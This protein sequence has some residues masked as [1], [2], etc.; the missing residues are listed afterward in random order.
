MEDANLYLIRRL[1]ESSGYFGKS[2]SSRYTNW[3]RNYSIR[4]AFYRELKRIRFKEEP[5]KILEIGCSDGWLIYRLKAEFSKSHNLKFFGIDLSQL[6][7]DFANQRK[8]YFNH[9]DCYFQVMD[10]QNLGFDNEGF[11][12][13]ICSELVEHIPEP[14]KVIKEV[15]RILE[16]GGL[17]IL[18]T[19]HKGGG[20]L[21]RFL[22]LI[23]ERS[24]IGRE[25]SIQ[26]FIEEC[27]I[28][29]MRLSSDQGDTGRGYGHISVKSKNEWVV[30]F[31]NE[32]F[33]IVSTK[34]T[35]GLLFGSSSLDQY[36]ILFAFTVILDTFLEKLPF[37]YLWSE[38]LF[39]ELRK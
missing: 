2:F 35:G 33:K 22:R 28:S 24:G 34:G 1:E 31:K 32:G 6:D 36:R 26:Y 4:N 37:S 19:P 25:K 23:K 39:F 10:A 30:I 38:T 12:I 21:A 7:I 9:K 5:I 17:F 18:T 13:V 8:T 27:E 11:D 15:Y 29:K 16:K 3:K 14:H 20:L